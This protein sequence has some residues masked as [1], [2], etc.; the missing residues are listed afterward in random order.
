M[1][2]TGGRLD[3]V[4]GRLAG[5]G[6]AVVT[7]HSE[8]LIAAGAVIQLKHLT[9]DHSVLLRHATHTHT[10]TDTHRD[11]HTHT[12]TDTQRENMLLS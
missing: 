5:A 3:D 10:D 11:T 12:H 9:G 4:L 8:V 1:Q 6:E 7:R 2:H